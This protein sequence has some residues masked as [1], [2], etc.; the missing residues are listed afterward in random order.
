MHAASYTIPGLHRNNGQ[1]VWRYEGQLWPRRKVPYRTLQGC[2]AV[3]ILSDL[4]DDNDTI[5]SAAVLF[6]NIHCIHEGNRSGSATS[7][8]F[9]WVFVDR[10]QTFLPAPHNGRIGNAF[11]ATQDSLE[12]RLAVQPAGC[13]H[14]PRP[15]VVSLRGRNRANRS[16]QPSRRG[17]EAGENWPLQ[18]YGAEDCVG[19]PFKGRSEAAEGGVE[20][21]SHQHCQ[22]A[23]AKLVGDEKLDL[24][25]GL[26]ATGLLAGA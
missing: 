7:C 8:I 21:C 16:R 12:G 1:Q 19:T 4:S 24:A 26:C 23:I 20:N 14:L 11:E 10:R 2:P 3:S 18:G 15:C 9:R 17:R 25:L 6:P 5:R 13:R 22:R